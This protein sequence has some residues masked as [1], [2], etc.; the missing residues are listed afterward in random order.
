MFTEEEVAQFEAR[1]KERVE[2]GEFTEWVENVC[3]E[4]IEK[5]GLTAHYVFQKKKRVEE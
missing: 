1:M 5:Y 3:R 2:K 4:N